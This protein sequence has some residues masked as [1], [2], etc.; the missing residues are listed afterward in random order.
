M[1]VLG[2]GGDATTLGSVLW[3]DGSR[4]LVSEK[5]GFL[6]PGVIIIKNNSLVGYL[7]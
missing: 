5:I 1:Q 4:I 6:Y 3:L 2:L 7:Q